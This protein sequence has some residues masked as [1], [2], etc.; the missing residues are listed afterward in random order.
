[1]AEDS[2]WGGL[3]DYLL[4][5]DLRERFERSRASGAV[6]ELLAF[7]I[8]AIRVSPSLERA[9]DFAAETVGGRLG[10][11]LVAHRRAELDGGDAFDAFATEWGDRAASVSRTVSLLQ[12]AVDTPSERRDEVLDEALDAVLSGSRDQVSAFTT[13]IRGPAMG[14]YAFGV[15]LPLALVGL[16]PMLSTTGTTVSMLPLV[17]LYDLAIPLALIGAAAWLA[18]ARPA[19]ASSA[20]QRGLLSLGPGLQKPLAVGIGLGSA[21]FAVSLLVFPAWVAPIVG[22]GT[23][24]G[25]ALVG[26]LAPIRERQAEIREFETEVPDALRIIGREV[27]DGIP[28]ETAIASAGSR[29]SGETG[30]V[31]GRA[32]RARDRL[33]R[34]VEETLLGRDGVLSRLPSAR[35]ETVGRLLVRAGQHGEPGGRTLLAIGDYLDALHRVERE[36][37]RELAQ[38]TSTLGQTATVFAPVIAGVTVA[39]ATGMDAVE[40]TTGSLA[41]GPLGQVIGV[42]VLSLAVI[43]PS[44]AVVLERGFD[45]VAIGYQS[46]VALLASAS[47]YP[48]AFVAAR[49][50]VYV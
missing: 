45:P 3:V 19:V 32:A 35:A 20:R 5:A 2:A 47:L 49:T 6:P 25:A 15:M 16:L 28:I 46:G 18:L 26:F 13:D 50:L 8:L 44:L 40:S 12:V 7:A 29:L 4:L 30:T 37:R 38:T 33:G 23:G 31:L 41:V 14:I 10:H 17:L 43:L 42:Y 36:G 27:A 48:L 39:L 9:A 11:S 34:T 21:G 1:M 24:L 22:I